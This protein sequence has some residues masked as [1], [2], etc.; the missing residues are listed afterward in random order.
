MYPRF[1]YWPL[2]VLAAALATVLA[3]TL[4][5]YGW[6]PSALFHLDQSTANQYGVP[7]GFVVLQEPGYD[8]EQ[9]YEIARSMPKIFDPSNWRSL[10]THSTIAY[11]YQRFLLPL[12]AFVITLGRD[13][14]LPYAFLLIN[15]AAL[16][17]ACAILLRFRPRRPLYAL[18]L[19]LCPAATVGLHFSLAE[20]LTLLLITAFLV[21]F[22]GR[23]RL[24]TW[25]IVLL[26]LFVL[27]REVNILFVGF[28]LLYML[29]RKRWQ[30]AFLL[31]VPLLT[32]LTLHSLIFRIFHEIPF[33][34]STGKSTLPFGAIIPL[35]FGHA[36]YNMLTFS[37][38]ALFCGFVLPAVV[39][40]AAISW[41][42]RRSAPFLPWAT[43]IFLCVMIMMPDHI[44]GSVTSI[45]R[46][47]TP[48]YPLFLITAAKHD[49][50]PVRLIAVAVLVIGCVAALGL[51]SIHHPF[52]L[53]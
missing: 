4:A 48:V 34:W 41:K 26:S 53:S 52:T 20:P 15:V 19:A 51:A 6:N 44:W 25:D 9:Y 32:F 10:A 16:I 27:S 1:W 33:F 37:S 11:S 30:D 14:A 42:E 29:Y 39:W 47:I 43:F 45:G 17:G 24:G 31:L 7:K 50:L 18:A 3:L 35:L 28:L 21:R 46:V 49:T 2:I 40:T 5:P 12:T 22:D 8:G 38:I 23:E 13:S 36:G